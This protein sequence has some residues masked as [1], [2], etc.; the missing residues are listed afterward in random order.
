[1]ESRAVVTYKSEEDASRVITAHATNAFKKSIMTQDAYDKLNS[2][3][4]K[5]WS[6]YFGLSVGIGLVLPY[7]LYSA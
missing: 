7:A 4:I 3:F 5:E 1:M 2:K 6:V